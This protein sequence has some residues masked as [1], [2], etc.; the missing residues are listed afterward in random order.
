LSLGLIIINIF[1]GRSGRV[2]A[3]R[4]SEG[5]HPGPPWY[6]APTSRPTTHIFILC[7]AFAAF[8][9]GEGGLDGNVGAV[10]YALGGKTGLKKGIG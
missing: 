1:F 5:P 8:F 4:L 10:R 9:A 3:R 6:D 7:F 2:G